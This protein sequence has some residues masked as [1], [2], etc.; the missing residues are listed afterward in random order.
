MYIFENV[1]LKKKHDLFKFNLI[2]LKKVYIYICYSYVCDS[3]EKKD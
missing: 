1:N 2:L 3:L